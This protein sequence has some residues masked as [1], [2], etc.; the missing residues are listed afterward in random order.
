MEKAYFYD[1]DLYG[2]SYDYISSCISLNA[3]KEDIDKFSMFWNDKISNINNKE[4]ENEC[5]LNLLADLSLKARDLK[6]F[7]ITFAVS[8]TEYFDFMY[9][10]STLS[11]KSNV[12]IDVSDIPGLF[13]AWESMGMTALIDNANSMREIRI[14]VLKYLRYVKEQKYCAFNE[15]EYKDFSFS[16]YESSSNYIVSRRVINR[17]P[18]YSEIFKYDNIEFEVPKN[19]K[20]KDFYRL[21]QILARNSKVKKA[22]F[23]ETNPN[24][25]TTRVLSFFSTHVNYYMNKF[26]TVSWENLD[27][28]QK[29]VMILIWG[30]WLGS[31]QS[32]SLIPI[33]WYVKYRNLLTDFLGKKQI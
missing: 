31:A 29:N 26:V 6:S 1:S 18:I 24:D 3:N 22:K 27:L 28:N 20:E 9:L 21:Y 30:L 12:K 16:Y 15:E 33:P 32:V 8:N 7:D 17:I 5:F 11:Q 13:H 19:I 25:N 14:V 23:F 2:G 4:E 10:I